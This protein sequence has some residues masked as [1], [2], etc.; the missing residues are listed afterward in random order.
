MG[1]R[2]VFTCLTYPQAFCS[3]PIPFVLAFS[4]PPSPFLQRSF[5]SLRQHHRRSQQHQSRSG[6]RKRS[7]CFRKGRTTWHGDQPTDPA[8]SVVKLAE[9][10]PLSPP[11]HISQHRFFSSVSAR[12]CS[13]LPFNLAGPPSIR[14]SQS[15][16]SYCGTLQSLASVSNPLHLALQPRRCPP[17]RQRRPRSAW[18]SAGCR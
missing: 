8:S 2:T 10:T 13:T 5:V 6:G 15:R 3:S 14:S 18:C 4:H 1:E 9:P 11:S 7:H 17:R 16:V 12:V